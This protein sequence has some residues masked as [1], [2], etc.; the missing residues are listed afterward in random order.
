MDIHT[1][2]SRQI[3]TITFINVMQ[4][5]N[6]YFLK[7]AI[8][9]SILAGCNFSK[10]AKKDFRTGL[11]YNYNGFGV[12][13]VIM[14]DPSNRAMASNKV[15]LNTEV[16]ISALGVSNYGLKEGKAFPGMMLLV[17][18]PKGKPVI[19][20]ADLFAGNQGYPPERATELR[21]TITVA[22][23]MA[24]GQTY[25]VKVH[26]WDKVTAGNEVNAETDLVVE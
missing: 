16:A 8:G 11:S 21:G 24:A 14:I 10:G 3:K 2:A 26:I 25:H 9:C 12:Q 7:L 1:T 19:D 15:Q 17:T 23:P 4:M 20:V 5:K 18:D 6:N 13:D 22:N